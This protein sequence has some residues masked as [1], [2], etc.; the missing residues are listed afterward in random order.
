MRVLAVADRVDRRLEAPDAHERTGQ[1]DLLL[2]AGDLPYAYLAFLADKFNCTCVFVAGNHDKPL[3][4]DRFGEAESGP[5]GWVYAANRVVQTDGVLVA[6]LSGS[7]AYNPGKPFQYSQNEMWEQ[8]LRLAVKI[9][10]ATIQ[11]RRRLDFLLTHSPAAGINDGTDY[12]HQGFLAV[13]WLLDRFQPRYF[14]HGHMHRYDPRLPMRSMHGKTEVINAFDF[15]LI[16]ADV[17]A[18]NR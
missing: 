4:W 3:T 2:G 14:I 8:A 1:V 11:R 5:R 15:Q 10:W 7:I 17:G 13:R 16:D 12:A 6:G 18:P 9:M